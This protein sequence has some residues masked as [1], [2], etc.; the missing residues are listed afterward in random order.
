MTLFLLL[1][2]QRKEWLPPDAYSGVWLAPCVSFAATVR[3]RAAHGG[4]MPPCGKKIDTHFWVPNL[5]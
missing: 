4:R 1:F 3:R 2:H 5:A